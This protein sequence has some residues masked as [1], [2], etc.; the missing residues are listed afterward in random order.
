MNWLLHEGGFQGHWNELPEEYFD[1]KLGIS[2][3]ALD[4]DQDC[5]LQL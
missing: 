4:H 2:V 5:S 3:L 1:L